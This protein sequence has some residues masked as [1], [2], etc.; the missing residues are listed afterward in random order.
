MNIPLLPRPG[1]LAQSGLWSPPRPRPEPARSHPPSLGS[2][3]EVRE[4]AG[5]PAGGGGVL[6]SAPPA[7]PRTHAQCGPP[8]A[9]FQALSAGPPCSPAQGHRVQR[10]MRARPRF[11]RAPG[12]AAPGHSPEPLLRPWSRATAGRVGARSG[13]RDP[14]YRVRAGEGTM[15]APGPNWGHM[16]PLAAIVRPGTLPHYRAPPLAAGPDVIGLQTRG[17]RPREGLSAWLRG[18]WGELQPRGRAEN[19]RRGRVSGTRAWQP[20]SASTPRLQRRRCP[21]NPPF[22]ERQRGGRPLPRAR[23]QPG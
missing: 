13:S 12:S 1:P 17:G 15:A 5:L 6:S 11:A 14:K 23:G 22:G 18:L 16:S 10:R 2:W 21:R 4:E 9:R 8:A 3:A 20:L 19:H 7:R